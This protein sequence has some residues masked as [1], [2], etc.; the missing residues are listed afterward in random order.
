VYDLPQ[1]LEALFEHLNRS[2]GIQNGTEIKIANPITGKEDYYPSQLSLLLDLHSKV[3]E[4]HQNTKEIYNLSFACQYQQNALFSGIGIPIVYNKLYTRYGEIPYISH[5]VSKGSI[6]TSLT[7]IKA[8]IGI[9]LGSTLK[10]KINSNSPFARLMN[11]G[12]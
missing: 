7:T 12:K 2:I 5:Q 9:L 10:S 6:N 11:R 8:N 1:L 3:T 4:S